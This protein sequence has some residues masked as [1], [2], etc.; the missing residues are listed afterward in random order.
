MGQTHGE[1]HAL[2]QN[3]VNRASTLQPAAI[4]HKKILGSVHI[5]SVVTEIKPPE[6]QSPPQLTAPPGVTSA[7]VP[8]VQPVKLETP[9][10]IIKTEVDQLEF[11]FDKCHYSI[12]IFEELQKINKRI[13]LLNELLQEQFKKKNPKVV[14]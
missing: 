6:V 2:N 10:P 8:V 4:D 9:K 13:D 5:P 7:N 14:S 11:D 3:I 1:L 12:T